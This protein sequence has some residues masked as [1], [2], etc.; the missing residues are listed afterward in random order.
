MHQPFG[1][2]LPETILQEAGG[3]QFTQV[4][5]L[6][7]SFG[8][9]WYCTIF[10]SILSCA[11]APLTATAPPT[12][13]RPARRIWRRVAS[14]S[15]FVIVSNS[16]SAVVPTRSDSAAGAEPRPR[17]QASTKPRIA[18]PAITDRNELT[19]KPPGVN[20]AATRSCQGR[21]QDV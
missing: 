21:R 16:F 15:C 5:H 1:L 2:I 10:G 4:S 6:F 12:T 20:S 11:W 18:A 3:S 19:V 7:P 9:S 17:H 14:L 8:V 13:A